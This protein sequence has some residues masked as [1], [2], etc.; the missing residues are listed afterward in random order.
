MLSRS[1]SF[2]RS[3]SFTR[4]GSIRPST[5][6]A[7]EVTI[8]FIDIKGFTSE[9]A[10]MPAG[11][12]GEWVSAFYERVDI[13]AAEHGV[14]KTEFRGDCCVCVAGAEGAIPAPAISARPAD[15]RRAD[16]ATRMLAFAAALHADLATLPGGAAFVAPTAAR[17]GM[18]TGWATFLVS[19]G[20]SDP[21]AAAFA[22][23]MEKLSA[24]GVVYVHRSAAL[25]WAAEART[26]PPPLLESGELGGQRAAVYDLVAEAFR[27]APA[28]T[29]AVCGGPAARKMRSSGSATF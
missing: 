21:D 29:G 2:K 1:G 13:I 9:C 19:D 16:Q 28:D 14:S 10:A 8:L 23:E 6:T 11:R 26:P 12:V 22:R 4:A 24:P 15:D 7:P 27:A 3:D 20:E 5:H 17:M 18:A 25:K